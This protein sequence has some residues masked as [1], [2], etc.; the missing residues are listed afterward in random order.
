MDVLLFRPSLLRRGIIFWLILW[1]TVFFTGCAKNQQAPAAQQGA[2]AGRPP[3]AVAVQ[4]A[5]KGKIVK[6]YMAG[7]QVAGIRTVTVAPKISGKAVSVPVAAGQ[8]VREGD[9]LLTL[10][11][12]DAET[13][14]GRPGRL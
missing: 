13:R 4:G 12:T 1:L 14:S 7:G 8:A 11:S 9:V 2:G 5:K 3:A 10:D 6:E